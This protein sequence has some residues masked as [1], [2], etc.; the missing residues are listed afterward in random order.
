MML[1]LTAEQGLGAQPAVA[2]HLLVVD[3]H[4]QLDR[5][6]AHL[7]SADRAHPVIA[8]ARCEDS[9][10]PVLWHDQ[11]RA[12]VGAGVAVYFIPDELLLDRLKDALT[13]KLGLMPGA[14]RIWWPE[15]SQRS[16]PH[17]HPLVLSLEG[18]RRSELLAELARQ[19]DLSRPHI[20]RELKL[21]EDARAFAEH[22]L[23]QVLQRDQRNAERLRDAH[24]ERHREAV[25]ADTAEVRLNAALRQLAELGCV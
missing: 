17:D 13:R 4:T 12:V 10:E 24:R 23:S 20:R 6:S 7:L 9:D 5:L 18:E 11:V 22:Q 16:D 15:L 14:A 8:L 1:P 19:F 3:D 21:S 2:E 25:R